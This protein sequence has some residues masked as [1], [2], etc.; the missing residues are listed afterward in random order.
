MGRTTRATVLVC[1][2][3]LC[4]AMVLGTGGA[5]VAAQVQAP[6]LTQSALRP[7]AILTVISGGVLT[8]GVSG[9]FSSAPDGLVLYVGSTIRTSADA[10]AVITLF[11]GSTVELEPASDLT[12]EEATTR[13]GSTVVQLAQSLG[14]S[15]HVVTHLTTADSRYEVRTPAATA[16]VRGTA[17]EVAVV[18]D[19]SGPTTTVTTTE[20]LVAAADAAATAE[21]LVTPDRTTTVR[22]NSAPEP[23]RSAPDAQRVVTVTALSDSSLVVDPLGRANGFKDGKVVAQTPGARVRMENGTIVVTLP[24]VP[25]GVFLTT[26]APSAGASASVSTTVA[27]QGEE[28]VTITNAAGSGSTT[29]GVEVRKAGHKPELRA[30]SADE[31]KKLSDGKGSPKTGNDRATATP[32]SNVSATTKATPRGS[33]GQVKKP[34]DTTRPAATQRRTAPP[35]PSPTRR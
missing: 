12:I 31:T 23:P 29:S 30:L 28:P 19:A 32:R 33:S 8:R 35:S 2:L 16:S 10:R 3:A 6:A 22:A 4:V 1:C 27:D 7:A 14:R 20:G 34:D 21:V 15:W 13:G 9:D 17:F 24:N 5:P 26:A 18:D 11:E 25:E